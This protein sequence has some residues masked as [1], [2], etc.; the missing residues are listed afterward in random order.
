MKENDRAKLVYFAE[1]LDT[2]LKNKEVKRK[3]V[4]ALSIMATKIERLLGASAVDRWT[5]ANTKYNALILA[6]REL[7]RKG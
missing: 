3:N 1:L 2:C 7:E 6:V 5:D 4:K